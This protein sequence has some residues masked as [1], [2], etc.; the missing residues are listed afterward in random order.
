MGSRRLAWCHE[1]GG[2]S[3]LHVW[4]GKAGPML[5]EGWVTRD[6]ARTRPWDDL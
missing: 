2:R 1:H 5:F 4:T 3:A 6:T